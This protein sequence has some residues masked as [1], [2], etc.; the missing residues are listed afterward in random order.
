VGYRMMVIMSCIHGQTGKK[1]TMML[2][3]TVQ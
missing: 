1:L 3:T 2:C